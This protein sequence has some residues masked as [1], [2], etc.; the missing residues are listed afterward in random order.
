M[1]LQVRVVKGRWNKDDDGNWEHV[2]E[3]STY[4]YMAEVKETE[5]FTSLEGKIRKK[6][7]V[8]DNDVVEITY[9]WPHL[10]K[11]EPIQLKT[12]DD[13][14]LFLAIKADLEEVYL[15]VRVLRGGTES[16]GKK[17]LSYLSM[18]RGDSGFPNMNTWPIWNTQL[19]PFGQDYMGKGQAIGRTQI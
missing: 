18:V 13:V 19:P 12:D 8:Y 1:A 11:A 6:L 16:S 7:A 14:T 2:P 17:G 5:S 10:R 15:R 9:Q 3:V 4:E